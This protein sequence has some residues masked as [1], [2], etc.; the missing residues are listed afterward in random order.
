MGCHEQANADHTF[1][2]LAS[3][4]V[5][6]YFNKTWVRAAVAVTPTRG[7]EYV[8]IQEWDPEEEAWCAQPGLNWL[9]LSRVIIALLHQL[10]VRNTRGD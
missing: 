6:G 1:T 9:E 3:V 5:R 10:N 2:G 7:R 4:K 8:V